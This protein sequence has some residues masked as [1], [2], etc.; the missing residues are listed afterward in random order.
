MDE[1]AAVAPVSRNLERFVHES[2]LR[3]EVDVVARAG[4]TPDAIMAEVSKGADLVLLGVGEPD[5]DF[6]AYF[7][8]L[9][10]RVAALPATLQVMAAEEAAGLQEAVVDPEAAHED[11]ARDRADA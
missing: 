10:E 1:A 9:Q 4:R 8:D 5:D 6:C 2:R 3:S 7:A 11:R